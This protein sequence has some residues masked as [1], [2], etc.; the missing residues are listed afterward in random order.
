MAEELRKALLTTASGSGSPLV[1]EDLEPVLVEYLYKISP[2][3]AMLPVKRANGATHEF[4]RRDGVP[5][6][7]F[8]GELASTT[9]QTSS[10]SRNT[11]Q[12]KILRTG[13]G[14][15]GFA[16]AAMRRFIDALEAEI[17]G[18]VEGMADAIELAKRLA[19]QRCE[20]LGNTA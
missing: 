5:S 14:V 4:N 10:Y 1:P 8:E 7:W 12:V 17:T 20:L 19:P 13:G 15:S 6:A 2:L 18:A 16:R 11:V 9:Q 3:T